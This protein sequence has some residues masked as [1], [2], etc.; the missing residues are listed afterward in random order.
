MSANTRQGPRQ[1]RKTEPTTYQV[2]GIR[3]DIPMAHAPA[4]VPRGE[5]T[6]ALSDSL[7]RV[8]RP[9]IPWPPATDELEQLGEELAFG[10]FVWNATAQ[11]TDPRET[12]ALLESVVQMFSTGN[13]EAE[14]TLRARVAAIAE[15]KRTMC[16]ADSRRILRVELVPNGGNVEVQAMGA[17]Y[18]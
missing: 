2:R 14:N 3:I 9:Y 11:S 17:R 6:T 7:L 16:P 15:R 13:A 10:A 1:P 8:M 4:N 18:R 5:P 12:D